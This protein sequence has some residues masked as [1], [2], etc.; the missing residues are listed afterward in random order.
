MP[1]LVIRHVDSLLAER[2]MVLA[3]ERQWS[4]NE[5]VLDA[6]RHGLGMS[7]PGAATSRIFEASEHHWDAQEMAAF[8]AAMQALAIAQPAPLASVQD[9]PGSAPR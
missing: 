6:L 2:I 7:L 8:Q 3:R 1:D 5:V 9:D 4:V